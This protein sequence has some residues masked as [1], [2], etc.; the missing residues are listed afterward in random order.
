MSTT[1]SSGCSG[2]RREA[3]LLAAAVVFLKRFAAE[4]LARNAIIVAVALVVTALTEIKIGLLAGPDLRAFR[5]A[6]A[7]LCLRGCWR[8]SDR[9]SQSDL[10]G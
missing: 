5:L 9:D 8:E 1:Y 7:G 3:A 2:R 6:I 4:L 10:S